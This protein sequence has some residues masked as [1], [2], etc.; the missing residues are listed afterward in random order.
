MG[1]GG[2][3]ICIGPI[4]IPI[5]VIYGGLPVLYLLWDRIRLVL[6]AWFP[7]WFPPLPEEEVDAA[8]QAKLLAALEPEALAKLRK[9][10]GGEMT[11]VT[12][13]ERWDELLKESEEIGMPVRS[14]PSLLLTRC[15]WRSAGSARRRP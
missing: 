2:F 7:A 4:C 6:S 5:Q 12:E 13:E 14:R 1:K 3:L 10:S 11:E 9:G 8:E 15:C